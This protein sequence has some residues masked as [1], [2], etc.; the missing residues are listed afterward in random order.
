MQKELLVNS[1]T[2]SRYVINVDLFVVINNA[3]SNKFNNLVCAGAMHSRFSYM[4]QACG[5]HHT[6]C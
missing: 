1:L 6:S 5:A 2:T 4:S 3:T